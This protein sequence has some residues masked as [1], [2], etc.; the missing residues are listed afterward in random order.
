MDKHNLQKIIKD[1]SDKITLIAASKK[2]SSMKIQNAYNAGIRHFG[3]NYL[4]ELIEKY[5]EGAYKD[6]T[7]HF[8]GHIQSKKCADICKYADVIHTVDREKIADLLNQACL[9][10][11]KT[12]DIFI[13]VNLSKENNKGGCTEEAL[14][15]LINYVQKRCPY[16]NLVGLMTFPPKGQGKHY[17]KQ[18]KSL[19]EDFNLTQLSIGTSDD[20]LEA[21]EEGATHIRLGTT[22]FGERNV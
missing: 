7:V 1:L 4:Q 6:A 10:Q 17:Y 13:Q 20:Y 18:L 5:K 11:Q 8:I 16:L 14:G 19:S 2:Q 3:E 22:I 21:I 12:L 15:S 9:D